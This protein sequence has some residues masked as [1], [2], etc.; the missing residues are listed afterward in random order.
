M[1]K[2]RQACAADVKQFCPN[3]KPGGGRILQCLEEHFKEVSDGCYQMLE[4]QAG[5]KK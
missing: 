3:V 1:H 2:F 4:K 5:R